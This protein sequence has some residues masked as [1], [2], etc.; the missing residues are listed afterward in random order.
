MKRL[1]FFIF[2]VLMPVAS[3][4]VLYD[5]DCY[6]DGRIEITLEGNNESKAYTNEIIVK[7]SDNI[8]DGSWGSNFIQKSSV[9]SKKYGT[10]ISKEGIFNEDRIYQLDVSYVLV[11]NATARY[12]QS[13]SFT[14]NCPGLLFACNLMNLSISE[15]YTQNSKFNALLDIQGLRQSGPTLMDPAEVINYKIKAEN[16]YL[17][18]NTVISKEGVLPKYYKITYLKNNQYMLEFNFPDISKRQIFF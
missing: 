18:L 17:G 12:D 4:L 6:N 7:T 3:S 10:F 11:E 16:D 8:V 2:L 1:M 13:L 15:C 5:V 14:V 9:L